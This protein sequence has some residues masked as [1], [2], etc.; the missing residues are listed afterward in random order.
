MILLLDIGNTSTKLAT[1]N[2][3]TNQ[4]KNYISFLTC[5]KNI[6]SKVLFYNQNKNIK[7]ALISSV[8]PSIYKIIKNTIKKNKIKVHELKDCGHMIIL[9]K[10]FEMREKIGEFL[11]K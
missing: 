8:V 10:A 6:I 9:E 7:Y 5:K 2:I 4:I 11:K 1:Y 3:K